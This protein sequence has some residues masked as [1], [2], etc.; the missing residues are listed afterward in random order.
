M[1]KLYILTF[2]FLISIVSYGQSPIITMVVDGP[3]SGGNPKVVE[4][5]ADGAVDFALYSIQNQ[6]NANT[7][8]FGNTQDLSALG[9]VT[10]GFVYITT[11]GSADGIASD[12]PTI[13]AG[14]TLESNTVNING[15]DRIR[16]ILNSDLSV[17]DQFG[18]SDTDGSGSTWEYLD[19]YAKRVD[20]T[21]PDG[22]FIEANW[23]F[24]GANTLDG[25]GIC[26]GG[27]VN[28]ETEVGGVGTYSTTGSTNP[29]LAITAPSDGAEFAPGTTEVTMSVITQNFVV[30]NPGMGDGHIHWQLNTV[31]QPMKYDLDD[32]VI[33]VTDGETYTVYMELVDDS[34]TPIAPAVNQTITFSVAS[35]TT[36]A[37]IAALRADVETNG[38]G[39]YYTI[40]GGVTV[41][42]TD[43]YQNRHWIQDSNIAGVL[44][45]DADDVLT[46]Y[47]EGDNIS[48]LQ[49]TTLISN[50][51]L[52]FIPTADSATLNGNAMVSPQLVTIAELN[53]NPDDYESELI[54][55]ANVTFVDGDGVAT[56]STGSNYDLTDGT[57]TLV[58]RTEFF[59]ADYID[60][61]IPSTE[62]PLVAGV[63]GEFNGTAQIY[64]RSM[65]DLT[66]S[67]NAVTATQFSVYPNPTSL[68]YVNIKS[69]S[70]SMMSVQIFDILGKLV[71]DANT[72]NNTISLS[73]INSGIYILKVE[74]DGNSIT[75]KLVIK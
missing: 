32:V 75:K 47:S 56:F 2:L 26:S 9:T 22:A 62:L 61:V 50:G 36:V 38:A 25:L 44:I 14:T 21:G 11:G 33:P 43:G 49:G 57:N 70:A 59:G 65:S 63:A 30:A 6:T 27:T 71:K 29:V 1:K 45:Y 51:V 66:L 73:N 60:T 7:G 31:M 34:H 19:S 39:G 23:T 4:I 58:K 8:D 3:C 28:V 40:S 52:R 72:T 69:N 55:V 35:G 54:Q 53:A 17:V 48:G 46:T 12:F 37:D 64:V 20:G 24:G 13:D 67:V 15:D 42:H 41:T 16:L 10:D 18:V 68:G 5:Y 74:Q